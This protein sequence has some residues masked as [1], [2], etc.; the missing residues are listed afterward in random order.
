[1]K[2]FVACLVLLFCVFFLSET[3]S[4]Q[5]AGGRVRALA[6][7]V[8]CVAKSSVCRVGRAGCNVA[9]RT[10]CAGQCAAGAAVAVTRQA[11]V[12]AS[13]PVRAAKKVICT[14]GQCYR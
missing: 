2:R 1:M 3:A 11:V 6:V 9:G 10:V 4:A 7:K 13:Q 14:G 12:V 5:C 8:R